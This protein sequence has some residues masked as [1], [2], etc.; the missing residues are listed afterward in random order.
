MSFTRILPKVLFYF[1]FK[2]ILI[3]VIHQL[4][5]LLLR[6][7]SKPLRIV[8]CAFGML[9]L[10][11]KCSTHSNILSVLPV[12]G[13]SF[14]SQIGM[15]KSPGLNAYLPNKDCEWIITVPNGQQIEMQFNYFDIESHESCKFDGLEIRNGGT[16]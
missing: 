6:L 10:G 12:C 15:I 3:F 13:G 2:V 7:L 14:Y 11:T 9:G 16:K 4:K 8:D 1:V 5:I